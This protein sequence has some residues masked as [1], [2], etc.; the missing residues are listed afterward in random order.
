MTDILDLLNERP[1]LASGA[2]KAFK[3]RACLSQIDRYDAEKGADCFDRLPGK[4]HVDGRVAPGHDSGEAFN[5]IGTRPSASLRPSLPA[6][7]DG[8]PLRPQHRGRRKSRVQ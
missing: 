2:G 8:R 3:N 7:A 5:M 1:A 6:P 4:Q